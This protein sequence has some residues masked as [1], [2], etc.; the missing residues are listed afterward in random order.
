MIG[1]AGFGLEGIHPRDWNSLVGPVRREGG[2]ELPD[3]DKV[4][5]GRARRRRGKGRE[6]GVGV[7]PPSL[8]SIGGPLESRSGS[9]PALHCWAV[10]VKKEWKRIDHIREGDGYRD[11]RPRLGNETG[12]IQPEA[13]PEQFQWNRDSA[14]ALLSRA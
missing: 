1:I 2:R 11:G 4:R 8:A 5:E 14:H 6:W 10:N 7:S 3:G 12:V 13:R 9:S